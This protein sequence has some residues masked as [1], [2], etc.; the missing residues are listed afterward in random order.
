MINKDEKDTKKILAESF[1]EQLLKRPFEKI[2]IKM[3]T[4]GA[5]VIR[6]TFYNYYRDKYEVFEYILDEELM[7]VIHALIDNGMEREAIKMIFTY[8][9]KNGDFYSEAF[10]VKGQNSFE[11]ILLKRI[12]L[13]FQRIIKKHNITVEYSCNILS[14]ENVA[15][16]YSIGIV[17][18]LKSWLLEGEFIDVEP[19]EMFEAYIFLITHSLS[20]II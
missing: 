2:T 9:H 18:I 3:I 10:K 8:F 20:D 19:D 13:L 17:Y 16:Y 12:T 15:R 11:E 14:E 5:G 6:P 1:K 4:D 7:N